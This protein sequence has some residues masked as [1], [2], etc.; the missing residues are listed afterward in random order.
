MNI[1]Y[2]S[3]K[4]V[5]Q[6]SS[7]SEI[8]KA[9]GQLAKMISTRIADISAAPNLNVLEQLPQLN[10]HPLKGNRKGEWAITVSGN[11]RLIFV[12]DYDPLPM[13]DEGLIDKILITDIIII[14]AS[15]DYH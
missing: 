4:L 7:A 10:C 14:A 3:N 12:L 6:L 5:R 1:S 13:T 15:E 11:Y 2:G 9:F 8:K